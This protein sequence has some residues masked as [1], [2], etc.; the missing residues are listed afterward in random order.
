MDFALR[1]AS[2]GWESVVLVPGTA[3]GLWVW[4][5]PHP[6]PLDLVVRVPVEV[7]PMFGGAVSLRQIVYAVGAEWAQVQGGLVAGG[8][9]DACGG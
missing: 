5:K 3:V 1:P 2:I 8:F 6:S 4:Y 9:I 7:L